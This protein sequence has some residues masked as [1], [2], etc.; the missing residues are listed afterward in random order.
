MSGSLV[1]RSGVGTQ[2]L[3]VSS[4]LMTAEV[5]GRAQAPGGHQ[6]GDLLG[7]GVDDV[8][9]A[10]V[11]GIDLALI[12]VDADRVKAGAGE[13]D[14]QR[15]PHVAEADDPGARFALANLVQYFHCVH[16]FELHSDR[17]SRS[18]SAIATKCNRGP[19]A[20]SA[21]LPLPRAY[22]LRAARRRRLHGLLGLLRR[23]THRCPPSR[24]SASRSQRRSASSTGT[25]WR[26]MS[27]PMNTAWFSVCSAGSLSHASSERPQVTLKRQCQSR[28]AK[29]TMPL[30][31]MTLGGQAFEQAL[32]RRLIEDVRAPVEERLE[33]VAMQVVAG[34]ARLVGALAVA[35]NA[36]R[37]EHLGVDR[38]AHALELQRACVETRQ[39]AARRAPAPR[40]STRSTLFTTRKSAA[41]ICAVRD[42]GLVEKA[43]DVERIDH[44]DDGVETEPGAL[45]AIRER[46][47]IGQAR[48]LDDDEMGLDGLD[49]SPGWRG[50][51][52]TRRSS[53]RCTRSTAPPSSRRSRGRSRPGRRCRSRRSR[54]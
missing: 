31:R 37:E 38:A 33:A 3:M 29:R 40:A 2:M 4:S 41:A 11:D 49:R 8:R 26:A 7:A 23:G 6:R 25:R 51:S 43:L 35:R 42:L 47:G 20:A 52:G 14:G 45:D 15:Q 48:R 24:C 10:G 18:R 1:F 28:P 22:T 34:G 32:E 54:S 46:L 27:R 36:G 19:P 39:A 44:G 50:R 30:A 17:R 13:L 16:S 5:G 12:D 53:S 9:R 21:P